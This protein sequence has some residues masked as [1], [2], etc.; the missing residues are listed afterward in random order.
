MHP[1]P[2]YRSFLY[3]IISVIFQTPVLQMIH[4]KTGVELDVTIDGEDAKRNT[5]LLSMY[6]Q[7]DSRFAKLCKAV[8]GWASM[9]GIEGAKK[10]RLNSF[11]V[12]MLLIQYLQVVGVLPNLQAMFPEMTGEFE[13]VSDNYRKKNLKRELRRKGH[14]FQ[15]NTDGLVKLYL[16]FLEFY[17]NF[18]FRTQWISIR[19]GAPQTKEF[20]S[21]G[22]PLHG[23]PRFHHHLVVADP[24]RLENPRNCA[25]SVPNS[26]FVNRIQ[27][28]FRVALESIL[29]KKTLFSHYPSVWRQHLDKEGKNG[30]SRVTVW[31]EELV[32]S[33][34]ELIPWGSGIGDKYAIPVQ[35]KEPKYFWN[36]D[37][38]PV[39]VYEKFEAWPVYTPPMFF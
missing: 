9:S 10:Q 6:V 5:Q 30:D 36:L 32:Q 38:E 18:D 8:K 33:Q 23:L 31:K 11:S 17:A 29:K 7:A 15:A 19:H 3:T 39:L 28:G 13:V 16:G 20:D 12:C 26:E 24:F 21:E 22:M 2:I 27:S 37:R 25:G 4:K 35:P 34:R 1:V 14:K